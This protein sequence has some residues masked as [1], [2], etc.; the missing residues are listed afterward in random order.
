M[1][2]RWRSVRAGS[3]RRGGV[4]AS[5]W[6]RSRCGSYHSRAR[7]MSAGQLGPADVRNGADEI[8]SSRRRRG[9][10]AGASAERRQSGRRRP[11]CNRAPVCAEAGPTPG[12]RC[13]SRKPATRS[14]GFS[15]NRSS[16][17]M[18]LMC[19]ASRNFRPPN[20]TNGMLRRVS[21]T[22]SGPLWL[23]VRNSTACCFSSVPDSR[24][25]STRSTMQR[26]WSASSRMVTSCGLMPD[27]RSVHRF[28]VKR[29][30]ARS[31]TPLAAARMVCVER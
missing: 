1:D 11:P 17:S 23:E 21:S 20:L 28:L 26:A 3:G 14:R 5:S 27:V 10:G 15:T 25:S 2:S 6:M 22:S 31:M 16:A 30:R 12:I 18:S 19:A 24:F 29:S 4:S 9:G 13:I 7:S 8:P